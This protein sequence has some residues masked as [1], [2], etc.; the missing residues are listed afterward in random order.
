MPKGQ[1]TIPDKDCAVCGKQFTPKVNNQKYCGGKCRKKSTYEEGGCMSTAGQYKAI[2]G[3]WARYFN[4]LC[5]QKHRQ[6][7]SVDLLLRIKDT[8]GGRCALSGEVLT[9]QL[10]RGKRCGTNASIDRI[11]PKGPYAEGNI[12]LVCAA[13]NRLRVDMDIQEYINWCKKVT[14]Y[15]LR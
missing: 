15:A 11:D 3:N 5:R 12:Q 7:L 13:L 10:E 14:D 9:C 1:F 6:N 8:Q 2:S 4:R